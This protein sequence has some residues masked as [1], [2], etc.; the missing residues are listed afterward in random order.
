[1][2]GETLPWAGLLYKIIILI[3]P[4]TILFILLA[5]IVIV[6]LFVVVHPF[7]IKC[8]L[9][10][11]HVVFCSIG[12]L[13]QINLSVWGDLWLDQ[14]VFIT[15]DS[16]HALPNHPGLTIYE[17]F[18]W[19]MPFLN[20]VVIKFPRRIFDCHQGMV[21][22]LEYNMSR[23][24]GTKTCLECPFPSY[25]HFSWGLYSCF[26]PDLFVIDFHCELRKK[27]IVEE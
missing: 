20:T 4:R 2:I 23:N 27:Q 19:G 6:I 26:I 1:M 14:V 13:V 25:W 10:F 7:S 5:V 12:R 9:L 16:P 17:F 22:T 11:S 15:I 24:L 8:N 3:G 18:K 21:H